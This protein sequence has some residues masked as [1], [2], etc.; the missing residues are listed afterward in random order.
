MCPRARHH[1][2]N[3]FAVRT[4]S[5]KAG[6]KAYLY[7]VGAPRAVSEGPGGGPRSAPRRQAAPGNLCLPRLAAWLDC[8]PLGFL[9]AS[10]GSGSAAEAW[11]NGF[12]AS[13]PPN[14][15][16]FHAAWNGLRSVVQRLISDS[17]AAVQAQDQYG[18]T[19]LHHAAAGA[20]RLGDRLAVA[21]IL[22]QGGADADV[23]DQGGKSPLSVSASRLEVRFARLL[24]DRG[25]VPAAL[26]KVRDTQEK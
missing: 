19:A 1:H 6:N 9:A 2:Q 16:L 8:L 22:L 13:P 20:G 7:A 4:A 14:E 12:W 18:R 17:P 25:A 21:M 15:E 23:R 3:R 10:G 24:L 5:I 11:R 26:A